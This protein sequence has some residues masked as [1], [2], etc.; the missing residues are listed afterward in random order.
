M[1]ELMRMV[2]CRMVLVLPIVLLPWC[3][4]APGLAPRSPSPEL[5]GLL[6]LG[7]LLLLD[8]VGEDC[9]R[10]EGNGMVDG[11]WMDGSEGPGTGNGGVN[12]ELWN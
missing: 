2:V 4:R 1:I 6:L 8:L 12:G 3:R 11:I 5:L 10:G 7:L 9:S